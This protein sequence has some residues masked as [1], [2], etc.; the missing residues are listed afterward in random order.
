MADDYR[1]ELLR[2]DAREYGRMSDLLRLVFPKARHLTP[3]YL[4]WHYGRNP[5]GRAIGCNAFAGGEMVGHMASIVFPCRVEGEE[6][7]GLYMVNGAVHPEHRGRRLQ[8]RISAAMFE[9][10]ERLGYALCFGTGNRW[11]TGPLLTRF[12]MV[13]PLDARL[14]FGLPRRREPDRE[15]SFERIWSDEAL[16]WRMANPEGCYSSV[17][18]GGRRALLSATG[19]PGVGAILYQGPG[20]EILPDLGPPPGPLRVW[21]GLDPGVEWK[22]S[23]FLPIPTR[24][25]PSPLNLVF[26][27]L[28]GG[29]FFPD[30][31][32]IVFRG[33]DFD[34]Y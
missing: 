3:R 14:G 34:A 7:R 11:S 23:D 22:G 33:I 6:R 28:T 13:R 27:D 29:G 21:L 24:L 31:D 9:E 17:R 1:F 16:R 19:L 2:H 32:R 4:E 25:R 12:E 15:P 30:P 10:A 18:R 26:K 8:S 20:R 5:D